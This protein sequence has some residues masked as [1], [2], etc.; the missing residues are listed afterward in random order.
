ME[1]IKDF[2]KNEDRESF[3]KLWENCTKLVW[4][5]W[6]EYD[7]EIINYNQN[8]MKIDREIDLLTRIIQENSE[9]LKP[10]V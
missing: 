2:L 4:I 1:Y 3:D 5:D 7:E 6:R 10:K 9:D 8:T